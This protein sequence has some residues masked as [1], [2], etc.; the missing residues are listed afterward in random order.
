MRKYFTSGLILSLFFGACFAEHPRVE[1]LIAEKQE[2]MKK[3]EDCQG[4]TKA[5]K[6]AGISTL[7]VTAAGVVANVAEAIVLKDKE[8]DLSA[9]N[10]ELEKK[11]K[12]KKEREDKAKKNLNSDTENNK[13]DAEADDEGK[14]KTSSDKSVDKISAEKFKEL[15]DENKGRLVIGSITGYYNCHLD[16][17]TAATDIKENLKVTRAFYNSMGCNIK[18]DNF[19][20]TE[21]ANTLMTNC[22]A[23]YSKDK[24][25]VSFVKVHF[26][27][28][29]CGVK[30]QFYN[31][32]DG[33]HCPKNYELNDDK[34]ECIPKQK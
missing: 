15:C 8:N 28:P 11:Q 33:C 13:T 16:N 32:K 23:V 31:N 12:E 19:V 29:V 26:D 1:Q 6:I 17:Q 9:A 4:T 34:N 25:F 2:K 7:G 3:L 14:T 21:G 20:S 5:L 24:E 22:R 10:A 18:F 27:K 30:E